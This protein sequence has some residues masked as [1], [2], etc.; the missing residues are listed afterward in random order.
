[1]PAESGK[2]KKHGRGQRKPSH[3]AYTSSSRWETNKE[4]SIAKQGKREA[5]AQI[6]NA[7]KFLM[8]HCVLITNSVIAKFKCPDG[9]KDDTVTAI[10]KRVIFLQ[11]HGYTM[12]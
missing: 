1:M 2:S 8:L 6:K 11:N 12:K 4:L 3:S 9:M 10:M 5:K 7:V